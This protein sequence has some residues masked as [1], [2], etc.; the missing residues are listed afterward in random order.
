MP[1]YSVL[2]CSHRCFIFSHDPNQKVL[3]HTSKP[4]SAT[5]APPVA[6]QYFLAV[7]LAMTYE[8]LDAYLS[9][10]LFHVICSCHMKNVLVPWTAARR[11]YP[12]KQTSKT[13]ATTIN[14]QVSK[15]F[16]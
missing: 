9:Y 5:A 6:L 15:T 16:H 14:R 12:P 1:S 13:V 7:S 11:F 10:A 4:S 2:A 8:A 3:D